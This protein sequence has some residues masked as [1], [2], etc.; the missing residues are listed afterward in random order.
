MDDWGQGVLSRFG[1]RADSWHR[2]GTATPLLHAITST[3]SRTVG[4][5]SLPE[6]PC[7][8]VNV[9]GVDEKQLLARQSE[10]NNSATRRPKKNMFAQELIDYNPSPSSSCSHCDY[11]FPKH[12][13]TPTLPAVGPPIPRR[14]PRHSSY[15]SSGYSLR[16]IDWPLSG[17][18]VFAVKIKRWFC[19]DAEFMLSD[20]QCHNVFT[21]NGAT[22]GAA[23]YESSHSSFLHS[24]T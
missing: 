11:L 17:R 7:F 5:L 3:F 2:S 9:H 24:S 19:G 21:D 15:S 14:K 23:A 18:G 10:L 16:E 12:P 6:Q 13:P 8:D 4:T 22:S 20:R 1:T